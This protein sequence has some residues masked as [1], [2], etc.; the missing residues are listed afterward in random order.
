MDQINS[1]NDIYDALERLQRMRYLLTAIVVY[2]VTDYLGTFTREIEYM[3]T[4][5]WSL[6]KV[7]FFL[8]RYLV[9]VDVPLNMVL[10]EASGLSIA[11]CSRLITTTVVMTMV[12]TGLAEGVVFTRAYALS[13][14]NR[15]VRIYLSLHWICSQAA[16]LT[17]ATLFARSA[18]VVAMPPGQPEL[19]NRCIIMGGK[20]V[21]VAGL[22]INAMLS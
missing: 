7:L 2:G 5:A 11:T 18:K 1:V 4:G 13:K 8:S 12:A 21:Y 6:I 22:I 19:L 17:L 20:T 9:F 16:S 15:A 14:Q 10:N 3:H